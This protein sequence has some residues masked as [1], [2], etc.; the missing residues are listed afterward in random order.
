MAV[1]DKSLWRQVFEVYGTICIVCGGEID[2]NIPPGT[3]ASPEVDHRV[4]RSRGGSLTAMENLGPIHKGCNN[5][6]GV[7]SLHVAR[8]EFFASNF[9]PSRNWGDR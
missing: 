3:A 8:S 4:P 5:K 1:I 6:K 2:L 9:K 7:K